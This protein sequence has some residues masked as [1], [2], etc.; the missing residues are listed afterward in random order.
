MEAWQWYVRKHP[1]P[2]DDEHDD[3]DEHRNDDNCD[4]NVDH[5]R[6]V[7]ANAIESDWTNC[8]LVPLD[9]TTIRFVVEAMVEWPRGAELIFAGDFNVDL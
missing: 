4:D 9:N 2:Q 1:S 5:C 6:E 3:F 8:Y 7:V